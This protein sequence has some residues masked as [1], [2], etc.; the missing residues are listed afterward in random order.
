MDEPTDVFLPATNEAYEA[1]VKEHPQGYIIRALHSHTKPLYWHRADCPHI[2]PSEGWRF[3]G[4]D[5]MKACA[6]DPG[7]LAAWAKERPEKLR[8]CRDCRSK[9]AKEHN[10]TA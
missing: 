10:A 1:W 5:L 3:V 4:G 6:L 2:E 9:W 7:E 8:Y